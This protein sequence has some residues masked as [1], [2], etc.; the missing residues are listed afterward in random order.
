MQK[1]LRLV[2]L[3]KRCHIRVMAV[4]MTV[5][6]A[7]TEVQEWIG[8]TDPYPP[9]QVR[10]RWIPDGEIGGRCD[11]GRGGDDGVGSI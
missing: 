4:A 9:S 6:I 10:V 2:E 5:L 8:V 1:D 7:I 3:D 11:R